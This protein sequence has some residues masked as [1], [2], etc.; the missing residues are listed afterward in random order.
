MQTT[1]V[2]YFSLQLLVLRLFLT[3]I[4]NTSKFT[5]DNI[6]QLFRKTSALSFIK[7]PCTIQ[8]KIRKL[9]SYSF[10]SSL[11]KLPFLTHV[12]NRMW[13]QS[14]L[15]TNKALLASNSDTTWMIKHPWIRISYRDDAIAAEYLIGTQ[16][17]EKMPITVTVA[18]T[19]CFPLYRPFIMH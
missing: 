9:G 12:F 3:T 4:V 6:Q 8:N 16:K 18:P 7:L 5:S 13:F 10:K 15:M 1:I 11:K 17:K 19:L 14:A 2:L